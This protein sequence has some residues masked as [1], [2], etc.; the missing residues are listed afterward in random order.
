MNSA[1]E[2]PGVGIVYSNRAMGLGLGGYLARIIIRG[3][4]V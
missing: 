1:G 4:R 2:C 3:R